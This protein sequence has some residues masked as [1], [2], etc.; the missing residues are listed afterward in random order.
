MGKF[1]RLEP[2]QRLDKTAF[3]KRLIELYQTGTSPDGQ[4]GSSIETCDG[5]V[6]HNVTW[7]SNWGDFY[8]RL[9]QRLARLDVDVNGHWKS[10]DT[11]LAIT[12]SHVIPRLLGALSSSGRTLKPSLIHGDMC[13]P[14]YGINA[15]THEIIIWDA[16]SYYAHF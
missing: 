14:N 16:S 13:E 15:D 10:L 2:H 1:G 11:V 6:P 3:L 12:Y 7:Q 9:L 5:A 8:A 4:L